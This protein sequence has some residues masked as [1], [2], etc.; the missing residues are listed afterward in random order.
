MSRKASNAAKLRRWSE[1]YERDGVEAALA[2]VDEIFAPEVEFSP[3]LAREVEG[4]TL[5]GR[6]Q[7]VGFFRDLNG[8]LGGAGYETMEIEAV[9]DDVVVLSTRLVGTG[10]G[11]SVPVGLDLGMVYEFEDGLVRRLTAYGS[12]RKA[13]E[14]ARALRA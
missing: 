11:S 1:A 8:T 7:L 2:M 12:R 9:A 5:H 6:D 14:E 3:L 13:L 10:R 4:R